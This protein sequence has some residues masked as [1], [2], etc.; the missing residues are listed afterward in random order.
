MRVK[1]TP[2]LATNAAF[3]RMSMV[4]EARQAEEDKFWTEVAPVEV[5]LQFVCVLIPGNA[6]GAMGSKLT[7]WTTNT[8]LSNGLSCRSTLPWVK[9]FAAL[10]VVE[11]P[12]VIRLDV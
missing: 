8:S 9:V 10:S 6:S 1:G 4:A 11:K 5:K 7:A 12:I 3:E 2:P